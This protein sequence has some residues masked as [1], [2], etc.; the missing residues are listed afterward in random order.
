MT[1]GTL[2]WGKRLFS[3]SGQPLLD[4]RN[5]LNSA[6]VRQLLLINCIRVANFEDY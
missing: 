1:C 3:K 6:E 5:G 4:R 2:N